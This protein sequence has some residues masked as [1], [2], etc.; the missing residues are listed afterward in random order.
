[1]YGQLAPWFHLLTPPA[2]YAEEAAEVMRLLE[3]HVEG[4]IDSLLELGSGG[5]NLA[6]HLPPGLRLTLTDLAPEMLAISRRLHPAVEHLEAD[7]RVLRLDR[8]FDAVLVHDAVTYMTTLTDLRAAMETAFLH[9]RPGGAA[10]FQP[11][12]VL[13]DYQPRTEH[14]G[15]DVGE[16]GLRY[17]EWDRP[18]EPDGRTVLTDY[19]IVTREGAEVNVHHDVHTLGIFQRAEWLRLL[20]E[21][22]YTPHR[23]PGAQGLDIFVGARPT[24]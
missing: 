14:G 24:A 23:V 1:M 7:M 9:L 6:S 13:D 18:I 2:D 17:L 15:V 22:G 16:R 21:V 10:V 11:D 5:G 12:W 4:P 19:I 3:R 20:S 8:Q